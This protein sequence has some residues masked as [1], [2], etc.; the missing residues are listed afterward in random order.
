MLITTNFANAAKFRGNR[1]SIARN[2]PK[3][4]RFITL[5]DLQPTAK[6]LSE[7]KSGKITWDQY[8]VQY[9]R[10]LSGSKWLLV[11]LVEM[12][13]EDDV[14]LICYEKV[15]DNCHRTLIAE[16]LIEHFELPKEMWK[17]C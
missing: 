2:Q 7:Y 1:Y 14:V 11:K 4:C 9:N 16:Y 8:T 17:K 5:K 6:M 12:A 13:K 15:D 3:G 10:I